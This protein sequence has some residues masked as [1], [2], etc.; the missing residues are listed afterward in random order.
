[1]AARRFA[2]IAFRS[3]R[4]VLASPINAGIRSFQAVR[5][6][7]A[8]GFASAGTPSKPVFD[9]TTANFQKEVMQSKIPI[10]LDCYADWC[11]P[12]KQLTPQLESA[13]RAQRFVPVPADA[14]VTGKP[15]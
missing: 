12:C 11:G 10:I 14:A 1:M 2:S 5:Y 9:V 7:P 6:A 15:R 4:A 8:R 3:M 13:V